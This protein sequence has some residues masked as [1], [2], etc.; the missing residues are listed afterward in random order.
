MIHYLHI[1]ILSVLFLLFLPISS[2]PQFPE[3]IFEHLTT[4]DG[5]PENS[6]LCIFQDHLGY[7]WLGTQ[8]GLVKYDGYDMKVYSRDPDDSLSI[9]DRQILSIYEDRSGTMWI[10]TQV[11][12][13]RFDRAT[14]TFT[15]YLH[16]PNDSTSINSN[17]VLNICEDKT[18][19]FL[20]GT[21][22]GLNLFNRQTKNFRR[23]YYQD[24]LKSLLLN[25][26]VVTILEDRLT[27]NL[28]VGSD[29][30]ILIFD[31]EKQ[32]LTDKNRISELKLDL[33]EIQSFHQSTNG[34]IWIG[35]SKGLA[36]FNSLNNT[37]K[38]Y[39]PIPSPGY[40]I[41]N[42]ISEI[43]E[44]ENGFIWCLNQRK[45]ASDGNG[46]ICFDP[47]NDLFQRYKHDPNNSNSISSNTLWTI[48]KDRS[49]IIW[50]GTGWAGL[51][52]WDSKKKKF[53][54]YSYDSNNTDKEPFG[55]VNSL[56][57]DQEGIIW[58]SAEEAENGLYSFNCIS[59]KFQNYKHDTKNKDNSIINIFK[60]EADIIWFG[61]LTR[62]SL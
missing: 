43:T 61:T 15:S 8:N 3:P 4:A 10:G 12:L 7:L 30:K 2:F 18:G 50:V 40:N 34:T 55:V 33:G 26:K 21:N 53:K 51:N 23:I 56:I 24:S 42:Y 52:K 35:H 32:I 62:R 20:V 9:S 22:E 49:G 37:I 6:V 13:N 45:W 5:L 29:N 1:A 48:Y 58:F 27:G 31:K 17:V 57:E 16:N 36:R 19:N 39:Q 47:Q 59:N 54:R 11:G 46:L 60:D 44:D 28:Y 25:Y 41:K 38:Y 14:E